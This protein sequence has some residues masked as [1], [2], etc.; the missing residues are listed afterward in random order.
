MVSTHLHFAL[1]WAARGSGISG[2]LVNEIVGFAERHQSS[3]RRPQTHASKIGLFEAPMSAR[4]VA[5]ALLNARTS[6]RN[7]R[8]LSPCLAAASFMLPRNNSCSFSTCL[9]KTSCTL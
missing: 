9:A 2:K 4:A 1:S 8:S 5:A 7:P 3:V 6:S